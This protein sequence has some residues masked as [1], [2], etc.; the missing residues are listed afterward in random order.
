MNSE[1]FSQSVHIPGGYFLKKKKF[2][3]QEN[4][5]IKE[6]LLKVSILVRFEKKKSYFW[7][8]NEKLDW[9]DQ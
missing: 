6:Q 3:L 4:I 5:S 9:I 2:L 8:E 1:N 7:N